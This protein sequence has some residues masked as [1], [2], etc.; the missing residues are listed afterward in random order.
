MSHFGRLIWVCA[1][2]AGGSFGY[3]LWLSLAYLTLETGEKP[4]DSYLFGMPVATA[5]Q[6]LTDLPGAARAIYLGPFRVWDTVLPLAICLGLSG[7]I[8]QHTVGAGRFVLLLLPLGYLGADYGENA[9]VAA[10][11]A[12]QNMPD[13]QTLAAI[14]ALT[15]MKML[16]LICAA[17]AA[18]WVWRLDRGYTGQ[19]QG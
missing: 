3:L 4:F 10:V 1:A 2:V 12:A 14:G 7:V 16:A 18:I 19:K 6:Y 9:R 5:Q 15:R 13:D 17:I 8:W 11:L